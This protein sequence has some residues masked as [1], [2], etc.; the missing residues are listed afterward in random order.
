MS[1]ELLDIRKGRANRLQFFV[2]LIVLSI[3]D[4]LV[5]IP[6]QS[7][8]VSN[9]SWCISFYLFLTM[10]LRRSRDLGTDDWSTKL[11]CIFL[12]LPS[13]LIFLIKLSFDSSVPIIAEASAVLTLLFVMFAFPILIISFVVFCLLFLKRGDPNLNQYGFPPEGLNFKSMV[14]TGYS[15]EQL[16]EINNASNSQ[17]VSKNTEYDPIQYDVKGRNL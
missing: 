14:S 15:Q 2:A 7:N 17:Y 13:S 6:I 9:L 8:L 4:F 3:V 16:D 1:W 10:I 11:V 5:S 12:F